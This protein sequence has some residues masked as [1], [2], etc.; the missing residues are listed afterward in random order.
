VVL[1][2]CRRFARKELRGLRGTDFKKNELVCPI[3]KKTLGTRERG[4]EKT[5]VLAVDSKQKKRQKPSS[6]I[7]VIHG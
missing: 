4:G 6:N 2:A 5:S 3:E 7:E 1:Q